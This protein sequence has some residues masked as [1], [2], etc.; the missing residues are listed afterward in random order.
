MVPGGSWQEEARV[1]QRSGNR[2]VIIGGGVMGLMTAYYA[3]PLAA[4]V[5]VLDKARIGDPATASFGLTRSVRNDYL[6][7]LYARLAA[8]AR[9][10]WLELQRSAGEQLLIDCGC[11]NLAAASVTPGI[12]AVYGAQAARV[13]ADLGLRHEEFTGPQLRQRFPQFAADH[14][15]LDVDAG[16]AD[17]QAITR[18]LRDALRGR[19]VTVAER[20]TVSGISRAADGWQVQTG[21]GPVQADALVLTAGLG[22]N[23]LLGLIPGCPVRFSLRPDR[24]VQSKYFIPAAASRAPFTE[25]QLP[26]FAYLDVGIYG[27]PLYD[28]KTPGVKIGYYNPPDAQVAD[29]VITGVED[30]VARCMPGLADAEVVDVAE[31]SGVDTCA[32]DLVGDDTFILGPVPGAPGVFTGVGWR[33]TGYKYAPW[34]GRVLSQLAV[35]HGTVYDISPFD[36]ARFA[37]GARAT[38]VPAAVDL[39]RAGEESA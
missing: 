12:D 17:V 28:G 24:P 4:R 26:V 32:Y 30:F 23:D 31:A 19:G 5:T 11:L 36:P 18:T 21:D 34:V 25:R 37:A 39:S 27:H 20:A 7:P 35:Q 3:A 15:W 16:F 38:A 9:R 33:G 8:E 14:G 2:L 22:T 29:G 6:D 10:L 13:L 1:D